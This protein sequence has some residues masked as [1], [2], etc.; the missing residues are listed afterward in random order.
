MISGSH[1]N[2]VAFTN[3]ASSPINAVVNGQVSRRWRHEPYD[4]RASKVYLLQ[5]YTAQG[6]SA[7]AGPITF[8]AAPLKN[9]SSF[10]ASSQSSSSS[11]V[12]SMSDSTNGRHSPISSAASPLASPPYRFYPPPPYSNSVSANT[13]TAA[14]AVSSNAA[15]TSSNRNK[16][17]PGFLE[18]RKSFFEGQKRVGLT[19]ATPKSLEDLVENLD[20][21]LYHLRKG[22]FLLPLLP[23]VV[24]LFQEFCEKKLFEKLPAESLVKY[25]TI[26]GHLSEH[27]PEKC[28]FLPEAFKNWIECLQTRE[29]SCVDPYRLPNSIVAISNLQSRGKFNLEPL[30]EK[31]ISIIVRTR[32]LPTQAGQKGVGKA[33]G[34]YNKR[35]ASTKTPQEVA[36]FD[37]VGGLYKRCVLEMSWQVKAQCYA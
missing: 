17:E 31:L 6:A 15:R 34:I 28:I 3:S 23:L 2:P 9:A 36:F 32:S 13:T 12:D 21:I 14:A 1:Q 26:F 5:Q 11:A 10:Q 27:L 37:A 22:D 25:L 8:I 35:E 7:P 4:Q 18:E 20:K 29:L 19:L 33:L 24:D 30:F 16:V